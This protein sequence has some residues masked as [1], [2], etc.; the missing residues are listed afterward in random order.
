MKI[1]APGKV[2]LALDVLSTKPNGYHELDMIMA[3]ISI[4]DELDIVPATE[5]TIEVEGMELPEN[6]TVSKMYE[7][8][9]EKFKIQNYS[10]TVKK[11]I[12][13]Q[14]GLAGGSTDAAAL[15]IAIN[16]M[17]SLDLDLDQ[18]LQI[19]EQIGADVP[20]CIVS[21]MSRVQ[22]IGEKVRLIESRWSF[23]ILLVKPKEGVSTPEVFQQ[24]DAGLKV[25]FDVDRIE[26]ALIHKDF[27]ALCASM[28]NSL[29]EPAF[30]MQPILMEI[31]D[32][33]YGLGVDRVMMSGSGTTMMGFANEE[34]LF[35]AYE[36]LKNQYDFVQIVRVGG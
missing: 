8:L 25:H 28:N 9:K 16:K 2:N 30:V 20:F 4:Y 1:Y 6:N 19:G 13:A 27:N 11:N 24:W 7:L 21:Q 15:L 32:A 5:T 36:A 22:G 10:I 34:V 14:A 18:M 12:P 33:M 35:Y 31:R 29:E 23:P 17:E 3:P 26:S